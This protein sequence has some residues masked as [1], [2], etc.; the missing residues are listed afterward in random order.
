MDLPSSL[1][2]FLVPT[3]IAILTVPFRNAQSARMMVVT[4]R[5]ERVTVLE[6]GMVA[7]PLAGNGLGCTM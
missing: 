5:V 3:L 7:S 4:G 6:P 1:L 2:S